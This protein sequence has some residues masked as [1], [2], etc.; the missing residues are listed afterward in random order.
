MSI[1]SLEDPVC[2]AVI[3]SS[4]RTGVDE[5]YAEM[6]QRMTGLARQ[7]PGFI[8]VDSARDVTGFGITVSYWQDL[9][10]IAAWKAQVE[11][12]E[13]QRLGKEKWYQHYSIRIARVERSYEFEK[14]N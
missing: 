13:A 10:S 14:S 6:S 9:A 1:D 2:Y 7:Q 3:F 11:H 12:L 5:G 4:L 8:A